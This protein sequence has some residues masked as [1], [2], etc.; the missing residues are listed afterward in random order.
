[1]RQLE[2]VDIQS[3]TQF[4]N[5]HIIFLSL[6]NQFDIS[7]A[8]TRIRI[9]HHR[10]WNKQLLGNMIH[11]CVS[12]RSIT[13]SSNS[14]NNTSGGVFRSSIWFGFAVSTR[15]LKC[16][17]RRESSSFLIFYFY[18]IFFFSF[19]ICKAINQQ[20]H[21]LLKTLSSSVSVLSIYSLS[22]HA[23]APAFAEF[24]SHQWECTRRILNP[25]K[26]CRRFTCWSLYVSAFTLRRYKRHTQF[27]HELPQKGETVVTSRMQLSG[28]YELDLW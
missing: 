12:Y 23:H 8:E 11:V 22:Y 2:T 19:L 3:V 1:M 7:R 9:F 27:V 21:L 25:S 13:Q 18:F 14:I 5:L 10:I 20:K 6:A 17:Y 15:R 28:L 24:V 16:F 26:Y 4:A